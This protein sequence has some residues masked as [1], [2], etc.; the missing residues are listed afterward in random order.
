MEIYK[1]TDIFSYLLK[2][3]IG[4]YQ[5][6]EIFKQGI[7]VPEKSFHSYN[8]KKYV[9]ENDLEE[10]LKPVVNEMKSED[11][12]IAFILKNEKIIAIVGYGVNNEDK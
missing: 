9:E 11:K 2:S 7:N 8:V 4:L 6:E 12:Y 5:L 3:T 10:I 1:V